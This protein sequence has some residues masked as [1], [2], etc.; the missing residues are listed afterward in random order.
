MDFVCWIALGIP[1]NLGF[2]Q[3]VLMVLSL[4]LAIETPCYIILF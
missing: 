1:L 3:P 2:S 4:C